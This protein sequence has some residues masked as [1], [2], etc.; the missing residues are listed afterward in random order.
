MRKLLCGILCLVLTVGQLYA[1]NRT[2]TGKITD[3]TG[4]PVSNASVIVKGTSLG[5][6]T[7]EDGT[8]SLTISN[9][10]KTLLISSIGHATQEVS[11]GNKGVINT[12]LASNSSGL[13]EVVVVGYGQKTAREITGAISK[14]NGAKISEV[15]TVAFNQAL[16]GKTA[17]VQINATGG[18]LGD[19]V[20]IRVRGINS[21]SNSS[22]P[23]IVIDGIPQIATTN[24]NGFNGGNGTRFDPLALV[25]SNDIESIEVLKDAGAAVIYGSRASNGVI[26]ITTKKGKKGT[27]KINLDAKVGFSN[28]TRLPQMLN[29]DQFIALNNE[30]AA[31]R[32]G[33]ASPNAS[34]A[35]ESDIDGNGVNDRTD[36]MKAL[37]RTAQTNDYSMSMSGGAEK[38]SYYASGRYLSQ[39]GTSYGNKIRSGQ[40]RLN[41]DVTPKTWFK[42]GISIAYSKTFNNGIL[43]DR[44]SAG[45]TI[46]WQAFPNVPIYNPAGPAGFNLTRTAPIGIMGWGNNLRSISVN[47]STT[48]LFSAYNPI[49][50]V[51][52]TRNQ[53]TAQD[54][55]ANVY[56][57]I[58]PIKGL[59]LTTKFGVQYLENFEDQYTSPFLAGL[60]QPYNGLVQDQDQQNKLWD[61]Q[62]YLTYDKTI[63]K[64]KI[65][66]VGGSEFQKNNY[67]YLYTG[68]GNFSDP[69][70]THII[71]NA[72]T[73][74]QPGTT[75][76]LNL[77]GG[78]LSSSG[79]ES[80][81]GRLNYSFDSK[82]FIEGSLRRDSYSGFGADNKWGTFPSVSAGWEITRETFMT[83]V[84]A[85]DYLK[86]RG[87][88]GKVGNYS[89][90]GP[91]DAYPLYGGAAYTATTGLGNI[92]A[93]NPKLRW[94]SA[95]KSD[96]GFDATFLK[97][98]L[99]LTVDLFKNDIDNLVLN[100]PVLYTVGI[101]GSGIVKNIGT[102]TNKGIEVTVGYNMQISKDFSWRTSFNYTNIK[103]RV[104]SLVP[105]NG[106]ADISGAVGFYYA[107]VGRPLGVTKLPVWAGVDPTTGFPQW[108][109]K[110]GS[111][112]RYN[113]ANPA[114]FWT[115]D[116]RN[117]VPALTAADAVYQE[118]KT[119]LPKWYGGFEN[120]FTYKSIELSFSLFYQGGN[121][122]YNQTRGTLLSNSFLNNSTAILNRWTTPGQKTDVA[123]LWLLDNTANQSST[124]FLEK[125][126]FLRM[127]T[128]SLGYN[129]SRN[130]LQRIGFEGLRVYGQVYNAFTITG[131][132]GADPEVNTNRFD[133]IAVGYDL[134]NVPQNRTVTFGIQASF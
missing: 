41:L 112:K 119:G 22:Q 53:N 8:Y 20:A 45:S 34:I 25:N 109:A 89:G 117:T 100:A 13:T 87:S 57:E 26:L 116:K 91:Y 43:S 65:G 115:D 84:R 101:P 132:K 54:I 16:A 97:S 104:N 32:F 60:G 39:E 130:I 121:Y 127:R 90:V 123:K 28:P 12:S 47:G 83:N 88:Y 31:N 48:A 95:N 113:F 59:K 17:G 128:I 81:F 126:D 125:G 30:K 44:Y 49:A 66:L 50:A 24:L 40:A 92:Q 114:G 3:E 46:G 55:R 4:A 129:L 70:F 86:V 134:R 99:N 93:G 11:I 33:T 85:I 7:Q 67:F 18:L 73:N 94:E 82:Y 19:G 103:N 68:A 120:T 5:T 77:T 71:D 111:I 107:S 36:W 37:Y 38:V 80:Y 9:S 15:P 42:S 61:W 58:Q 98:R 63:G 64:H 56:G 29:G 52:L 79:L 106:N 14:V 69:F 102:M 6:T 51:D 72:Y 133:N 35:K 118:G 27:A 74:V 2:V 21:I 96:I 78:N 110:D 108:Y 10:A 62:N 124:R 105:E 131:Y 1:Q 75:T 122:L 76:T 23:L